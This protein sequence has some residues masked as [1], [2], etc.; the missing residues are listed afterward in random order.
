[1]RGQGTTV[2]LPTSPPRLAERGG[3]FSGAMRVV[4][5]LLLGPKYEAI[6]DDLEDALD[7]SR[8]TAERIYAGQTVGTDSTLAVLTHKTLG[9]PFL[10]EVLS[11][12]PP[13]R[14]AV[15]AKALMGAAELAM[16][17]A[18]QELVAQEIAEKRAGRN[19]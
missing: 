3:K 8:R 15:V 13:D 11:R 2:A 18:E 7:V 6:I 1:M 16:L 4:R 9:P 5:G 12:V 14:R 17:T 19:V 10:E